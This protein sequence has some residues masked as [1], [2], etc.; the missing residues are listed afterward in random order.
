MPIAVTGSIATDHLMTFPG[1]FADQLLADQLSHVSLSFLVDTLDIRPGGV[2]ANIAYGL[3]LLGQRPVLV[4]A[5]GAD[6]GPYGAELAAAGVELAFVRTSATRHTARFLCTTDQD[7]NQLASFYPG[8]MS[9]AASI[10]LA[11]VV[12]RL[13]G[14]DGVDGVDLVHVGADT[15]EAMLRHTAAARGLGLPFAAD[16][17]QQLALLDGPRIRELVAGARL[18]FTNEY[19]H[20][21][22]LGKTGWTGQEVLGRVG[23]WV[24]TLGEKGSRIAVSGEPPVEVAAL[25]ARLTADPTGV[26]DAFRAGF[27]AATVSGLGPADAAR[28]GSALA[29]AAL[30]SVGPQTYGI[31]RASLLSRITAAYGAG[32]GAAQFL[33]ALPRPAAR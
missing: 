27:L 22:L 28:V 24:T 20:A 21:L 13:S 26:G 30:E 7:G 5:A 1:R 11:D 18:L 8:A 17:S 3:A 23:T 15:P 31:D 14:A 4:G 19:E 10:D 6:F 16:P 33:A 2:G 25:P 12:R 9:E 29:T 32:C